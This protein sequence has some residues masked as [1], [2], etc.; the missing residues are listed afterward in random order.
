M[1]VGS[2]TKYTNVN[3]GCNT[4]WTSI[5]TGAIKLLIVLSIPDQTQHIAAHSM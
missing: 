4:T 1:K 5:N 2:N 3:T